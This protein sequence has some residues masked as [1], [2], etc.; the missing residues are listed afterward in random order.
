MIVS[1]LHDGY[2]ERRNILSCDSGLDRYVGVADRIQVLRKAWHRLTGQSYVKVL[3]AF[4]LPAANHGGI[5]HTF[6]GIVIGGGHRWVVSYETSLPRE[7][8]I[9]KALIR[10]AWARLASS[11]CVGIVA[12]SECA[13]ERFEADL[14]YNRP[15]ASQSVR[16]SIR[17]KLVVLHPPQPVL[18]DL[19]EKQGSAPPDAPLELVLVGH[20]FFRK[21]GLE[22]LLAVDQLIGEGRDIRFCIGGAMRSGDY[23]SRAGD[24][25][26]ARANQILGK[27]K[28]RILHLGPL[29]PS[30]V[31][32]LVRK[33]HLLCLPTWG[34]TYGYSVLE[35]QAS[36]CPAITTNLRALPEINDDSCGW[37]I[38]VPKLANGD[39]DIGSPEKRDEFRRILVAGLVRAIR[40]ADDDRKLLI[41]KAQASLERIKEFHDPARHGERLK[42]I[43]GRL[44]R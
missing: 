16:D 23:A 20:D 22:T 6:N 43:Y 3:H 17:R 35:G 42:E 30:D 8:R 9:P 4:A 14:D 39:G 28:N 38:P 29:P 2:N 41:M 15:N 7:D 21:G 32:A 12:L 1:V 36:G 27:H 31:V 40:E 37:V 10:F 11:S 13:R 19:A 34:E 25:E 44:P 26:V 5:V 18:L 24:A 33:S